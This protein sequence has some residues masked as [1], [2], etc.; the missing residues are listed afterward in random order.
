MFMLLG[1][2]LLEQR[3][4]ETGATWKILAQTLVSPLAPT[5]L[6]VTLEIFYPWT[7]VVH[8]ILSKTDAMRNHR[9]QVSAATVVWLL[10]QMKVSTW[11]TL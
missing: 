10:S 9:A 3:H 11:P 1:E 7:S 2:R 5:T 8:T 6:S 4:P